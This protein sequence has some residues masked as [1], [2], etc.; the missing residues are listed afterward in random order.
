MPYAVAVALDGHNLN[1]CPSFEDGAEEQCERSIAA[2]RAVDPRSL[3]AAQALVVDLRDELLD[4]EL[5]GARARLA[6][7]A[8]WVALCLSGN[9]RGW[10]SKVGEGGT[11]GKG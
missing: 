2:A 1:G 10:V 7:P 6:L 3:D 9:N 4:A 5:L 11:Q 8:P